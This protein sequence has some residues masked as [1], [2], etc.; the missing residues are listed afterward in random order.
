MTKEMNSGPVEYVSA[1]GFMLTVERLTRAIEGAGMNIFA[2]IDHAAGA[3]SSGLAMPPS[4][5]LIYGNPL[6][7]TPIM[8]HSPLAGLE[9]PLRV[10]VREAEDGRAIVAFHPVVPMLRRVGVPDDL[11]ARLEP[12]QRLLIKEI[13]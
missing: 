8:R 1:M 6:G 12:A 3:R 2:R 5:V 4:L 7:G 13:T 10:L 11:S 9:L